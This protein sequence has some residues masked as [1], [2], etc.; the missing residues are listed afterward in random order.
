MKKQWEDAASLADDGG[1]LCLLSLR[2]SELQTKPAAHAEPSGLWRLAF[3]TWAASLILP[4]A[5]RRSFREVRQRA[6][7]K[8]QEKLHDTPCPWKLLDLNLNKRTLQYTTR[9]ESMVAS[10]L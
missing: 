2:T 4:G 6:D 1:F 5:Q 8:Q 10:S 3:R 7:N 9:S